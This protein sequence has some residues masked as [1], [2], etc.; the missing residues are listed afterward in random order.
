MSYLIT[1]GLSTFNIVDTHLDLT[2]S[3]LESVRMPFN[4]VGISFLTLIFGILTKSRK[5]M[6]ILLNHENIFFVFSG[7]YFF[8]C[9]VISSL[10]RNLG[11]D[12]H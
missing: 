12:T 10:Y 3:A 8:G 1:I 7:I 5:N 9:L 4:F 2:T 6:K 11:R